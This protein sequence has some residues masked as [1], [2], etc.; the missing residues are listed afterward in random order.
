MRIF[1]AWLLAVLFPVL[2]AAAQE[3]G[4]YCNQRYGYCLSYPEKLLFPQPEAMNGDGRVFLDAGGAERLRVFGTGHW[5]ANG[6][7][8]PFR[9]LYQM[10][11]KGGRY[12]NTSKPRTVT[13]SVFKNDY[14][15][16]SGT[17]NGR[18]FYLKVL[19][20]DDA[21]AYAYLC[22]PEADQAQYAPVAGQLFRSFR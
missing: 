5:D 11:L 13:Y 14:F 22:Y 20:K 8:I 7:A 6:D 18:V 12:P 1:K 4:S 16:V 9:R 2:P 10:E 19:R 15:V 3:T 21:F 17:E